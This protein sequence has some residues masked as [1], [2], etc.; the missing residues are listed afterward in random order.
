ME[1]IGIY[2]ILF[3]VIVV[4]GQVFNKSSIPIS[5][6][7]VIAGMV[8][9]VVPGFP[10]VSLNPE[11]VLDIFLPILIYQISSFSAWKDFKKYFRSI[12]LLSVGHVI[13]ITVLVAMVF[14]A[15]IPQLGW[16]LAFVLGAV[17]SP[18]DD[19]AIVSIA[20]KIRMPARVV[21]IL[22]GE[23]MLN[24]ATALILFRFSLAAVFTHEFS[25]VHA[26]S[27]FFAVIAGETLYGLA[28]GYFL[29]RIRSTICNSTL[30]MIVSLLTPFLAYFPAVMLGGC[31]VLATAVTGF[32]IGNYYPS[33]FTPEFR[34]ISRAVWPTL[35]FA[36]QSIIFLLVGLNM[37]FT[38]DSISSIPSH[39]LILYA[40]AVI[41][42]IIM[43]RFFWVY[44]VLIFLP[45]FLFPSI[46]KKDPYPPWQYPFIVSWAGMRGG[47][48]LAAALAVPVL[49]VLAE[50]TNPRN[51]IIF[52][53]FCVI[54]IT[55]LLQG[56]TLPWLLKV[57]GMHKHGQREKYDEHLAEL[58]SRLRMSEA[59]LL[60]LSEYK[61]QMKDNKK[62]LA[63][64]K[65]QIRE[66][67]MLKKQLEE[68]IQGH[69]G[70]IIH[71]ESAEMKEEVFIFTEIIEVQR[72]ELLQLWRE[73]KINL[74]VRNKL[75]DRLDHLA[76]HLQE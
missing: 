68:R 57:L 27:E 10:H 30:H 39:S 33:H 43:G 5:L 13:F 17:I 62:L 34:L 56:L 36:I 8:L 50:G 29:G 44:V 63:E 48:S 41:L 46:R 26:T 6:L 67:E 45:R 3:V 21:T 42:T 69:D 19:V 25:V 71:D 38:L 28:L 16:P 59:A 37:R 23:G 58:S 64:I 60:W 40:S 32:M 2:I 9:S 12:A 54:T 72:T 51:L 24:D 76:K 18:P 70:N 52:L 66:Q 22:E 31:G 49:P 4:I 61:E 1:Q 35:T 74:N 55:L 73:D 7:L 47:V 20:E 53:V 75:L 14:H 15:L 11:I 65:L